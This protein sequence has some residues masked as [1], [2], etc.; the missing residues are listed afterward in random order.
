VASV[1]L[2][3]LLGNASCAFQL[4]N[5]GREFVYLSDC[6]VLA[7]RTLVGVG[8]PP[9]VAGTFERARL[10]QVRGKSIYLRDV[11]TM[12]ASA[13]DRWVERFTFCA[14]NCRNASTESAGNLR[15]C[16]HSHVIARPLQGACPACR[17]ML[18]T[19]VVR[20]TSRDNC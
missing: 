10:Q 9:G 19:A 18:C 12:N 16:E 13:V 3:L 11:K 15:S 14:S 5:S 20:A 4:G 8:I 2:Q 7:C 17:N 1:V 6:I